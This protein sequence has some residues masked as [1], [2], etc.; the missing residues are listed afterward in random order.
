M[1][2]G[3]LAGKVALV[4]AS[5]EGIGFAIARRLAQDGAKVMISSR[6]QQNVD[7]ALKSLREES[8]DV[9][10]VTCHVGKKSD[11]AKLLEATLSKYGGVDVLVSNAAV[12]TWFGSTLST[13]EDS[14]DKMFDINVKS[15]FMLCKEVVPEMEKRGQGSLVLVA[16]IAG[17]VPF[18]MI[19]VYSMTKTALLGMTKVLAPELARDNI[20]INCLAPGLIKTKFSDALTRNEDAMRH[21]LGNIPMNRL[22]VPDD[23]SGAA[24]FL[25]S[26]DSK[27]MTGETIVIAGGQTSRL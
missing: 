26:D 14:Y 9:E 17:F 5:T 18:D 27:F 20:R 25:A 6:K 21:A 13:P 8:L 23:I 15:S 3:K 11:R 1:S 24:S 10:G 22:G 16:S 2:S 19:G 12:S 7:A 4:T